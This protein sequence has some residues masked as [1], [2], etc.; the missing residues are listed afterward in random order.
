MQKKGNSRLRFN[1]G[2]LLEASLGTSRTI[3]LNYPN[4]RVAED[5][6]LVPLSGTFS[7]TR[8]G[9]GIYLSGKLHSN[10]DIICVRC[11]KDAKVPAEL[12]LDDLYY[13]PAEA[14]PEGESSIGEDGFIDLAPLLREL[15]VLEIP[16]KPI[17][18]EDCLGLCVEC[19][20]DLNEGSCDCKTETID[21][22][23]SVL[24]SLLDS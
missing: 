20:Q 22:R 15:A 8:T 24:R 10:L 12:Q 23:F 11:L 18:K 14:A 1:F 6:E 5:L 4:V 16:I 19:G 7:A 2:F 17:C 21:P 9:E 13:Y 3:E